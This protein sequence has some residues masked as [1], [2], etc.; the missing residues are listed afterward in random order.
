MS[1]GTAVLTSNTGALTEIAS[2][3]ALF[4]D[5]F[6]IESISKALRALDNDVGMVD[7]LVARGLIQVAQFSPGRYQKRL[8]DLYKSLGLSDRPS[9]LA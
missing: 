4:V 1:A 3:A 9:Q 7:D 5:P 2:D 6:S 8:H